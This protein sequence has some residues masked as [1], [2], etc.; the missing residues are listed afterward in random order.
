ML[1][2]H[3]PVQNKAKNQL[4]NTNDDP[5]ERVHRGNAS[6]V[7]HPGGKSP[8]EPPRDKAAQSLET[9][10]SR[11]INGIAKAPKHFKKSVDT[12]TSLQ[13]SSLTENNSKMSTLT[14]V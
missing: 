12:V 4:P 3:V 11:L 6:P 10:S 2:K 9:S 13:L 5:D 8:E 7:K 14:P 1:A